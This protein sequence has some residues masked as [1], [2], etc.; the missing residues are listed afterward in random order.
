MSAD[1]SIGKL[2]KKV[3]LVVVVVVVSHVVVIAYLVV[4]KVQNV[5]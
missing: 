5:L 2:R 3:A 4:D 1:S